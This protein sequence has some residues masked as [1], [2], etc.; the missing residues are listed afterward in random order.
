MEMCHDFFHISQAGYM[1]NGKKCHGYKNKKCLTGYCS[2]IAQI[3]EHPA[4]NGP[5]QWPS[6]SAL[7]T[8]RREVPVS[9][10]GRACRLSPSEY[11][12]VFSE[13]HLNTG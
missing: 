13:T 7:K 1:E 11:S 6:G 12:M 10:P 9:N 8:G 2:E 5:H 4:S 3:V